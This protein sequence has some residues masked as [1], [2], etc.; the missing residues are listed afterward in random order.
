M[1][2]LMRTVGIRDLALGLGTVASLRSDSTAETRRWVVAGLISD[3]LDVGAGLAAARTT[4]GRGVLS[5]LVA[6]PV[7]VLDVWVL[8][9][10]RDDARR[11]AD[12]PA[13]S[14]AM[15]PSRSPA[16][17]AVARLRDA[18]GDDYQLI[19]RLAGGETGAHEMRGPR[20]E[21]LVVKWD[22]DAGS[23]AA[24]RRAV[25]LTAR[26]GAEAGWPVPAQWIV[27]D[28]DRM[29]VVQELVAG[30]PVEAFTHALVDDLLALH[31]RRLG[32]ARPGDGPA[33][34]VE[35]I[36]TLT[37]GGSGY[38]VHA[39]LRDHDARTAALVERIE[40]FG[41]GLDPAQFPN[42][43]LIHWDLHEGNLLQLDGR[44]AAVVDNDFVT[45][46]D[47]A[48]DLVTLAVAATDRSADDGVRDRI[49]AAAFDD[50]DPVRREA[51]VGH[52]MIRVLDWAIRK[53]RL[54]EIDGWLAWADRLLP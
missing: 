14:P 15:D 34:A 9:Q 39:S 5:A 31:L 40:A 8:A 45:T 52:L 35:L 32:L 6:L 43:D 10:L 30:V 33:A 24:R 46:G 3:A 54:D 17:A 22:D 1:D 37:V 53:H 19:G 44:L 47:A 7:V 23:Q 28:R 36:E 51:Y 21:R 13:L 12:R 25:G 29:Y 48:F 26:L 2:L 4:G 42:A 11:R 50:L 20:G 16:E 38:C 49:F 41:R 27:D 18:T